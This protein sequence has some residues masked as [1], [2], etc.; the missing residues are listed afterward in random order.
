MRIFLA[1]GPIHLTQHAKNARERNM[2]LKNCNTCQ[3][4][5]IESNFEMMKYGYKRHIC[6]ECYTYFREGNYR[7]MHLSRAR[8]K[9]DTCEL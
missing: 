8:K 7:Y 6:N 1:K 2:Q 4:F 5:Q 9:G 3:R